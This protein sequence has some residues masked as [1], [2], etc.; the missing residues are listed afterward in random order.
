GAGAADCVAPP[1]RPGPGPGVPRVP[2]R[3]R[4]PEPPRPESAAASRPIYLDRDRV[5]VAAPILA[6]QQIG[7]TPLPGPLIVEEYDSTT[8]VPPEAKIWRDEFGNLR[9][10][11]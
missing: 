7:P 1:L 4:F 2:P 6:R 9:M 10:E 3:L 8:I 11:L 5:W